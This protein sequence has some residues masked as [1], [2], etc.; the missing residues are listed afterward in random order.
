MVH[1]DYFNLCALFILMV[2]YG[3]IIVL[4]NYSRRDLMRKVIALLLI[5]LTLLMNTSCAK[6]K[7]I[8]VDPMNSV[9]V[10]Y[11]LT[12]KDSNNRF[13]RPQKDYY[14]F[15]KENEYK[16]FIKKYFI[17]LS[18]LESID[19]TKNDLLLINCKWGNKLK[20]PVYNIESMHRKGSKIIITI[21]SDGEGRVDNKGPVIA[22]E[23]L[24]YIKLPKRTIMPN[25]T[26]TV[27]IK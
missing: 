8:S 15:Y 19:F 21:K 13:I 20:G 9:S 10:L 23:E 25:D 22:V 18:K 5:S 27:N 4:E 12:N 17:S 6:D 2:Y 24:T 1:I 16:T 3:S 11:Q 14:V 26:I 7:Q